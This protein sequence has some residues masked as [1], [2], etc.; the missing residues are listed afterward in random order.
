MQFERTA[1]GVFP[2]AVEV[3]DEIEPPMPG[4]ERMAVEVDVRIEILSVAVLL[5]WLSRD[6]RA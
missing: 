1:P 2:L 5:C 4:F 6:R 3:D